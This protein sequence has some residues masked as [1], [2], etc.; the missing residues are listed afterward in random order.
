[1][2]TSMIWTLIQ[3]NTNGFRYLTTDEDYWLMSDS[4]INAK[5]FLP[6]THA[7]R[8]HFSSPWEQEKAR[9]FLEN[10]TDE[11]RMKLRGKI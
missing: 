7:L 3:Y 4:G 8:S 6:R 2:S 5:Y 10:K 1:M 9:V 11:L